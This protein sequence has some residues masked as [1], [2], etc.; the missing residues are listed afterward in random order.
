MLYHVCYGEGE[1]GKDNSCWKSR[2]KRFYD[3]ILQTFSVR[4]TDENGNI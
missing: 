2:E 3:K 1:L 4:E